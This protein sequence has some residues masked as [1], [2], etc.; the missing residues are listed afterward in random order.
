MQEAKHGC[1]LG[2][3]GLVTLLVAA[4]AGLLIYVATHR[5]EWRQ[6]A[7]AQTRL[8]VEAGT[9]RRFPE[10][11]PETTIEQLGKAVEVGQLTGHPSKENLE[12]LVAARAQA[13][14]PE[15]GGAETW[16]EY[17]LVLMETLY[18]GRIS[19]ETLADLRSRMDLGE[20]RNLDPAFFQQWME[21]LVQASR[22]LT[23]SLID[24]PTENR[25]PASGAVG[26]GR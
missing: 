26:E 17:L 12:R 20:F 2:C 1:L 9:R 21:E 23:D 14:N 4:A 6:A 22:P 19:P 16:A 15:G 18:E 5:E 25:D 7:A 24:S 8:Q 11:L 13:E 10:T 3:A